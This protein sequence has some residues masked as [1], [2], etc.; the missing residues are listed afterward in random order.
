MNGLTLSLLPTGNQ[1]Y[2]VYPAASDQISVDGTTD[3]VNKIAEAIAIDPAR[4][5]ILQGYSQGASATVNA[6]ALLNGT[7]ADAVKAIFLIGNPLH[8]PGLACNVDDHGSNGSANAL[9]LQLKLLPNSNVVPD[10]FVA[11][12][13]DVCIPGDGICDSD[14]GVGFG[15]DGQHLLYGSDTNVQ[16]L[17][18]FFMTA[19]L[20]HGSF[21]RSVLSLPDGLLGVL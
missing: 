19:I 16:M 7:S 4:C 8:K 13:L 5:V 11:R 14:N 9:G 3:I 17:G 1:Y 6:L 10:A 20:H 2:T 15:T 18:Y 12:T 21:L